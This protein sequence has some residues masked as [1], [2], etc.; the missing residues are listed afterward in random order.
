MYR[1]VERLSNMRLTFLERVYNRPRKH[2]VAH[3]VSKAEA[4]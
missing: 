3:F 2:L 1:G 4:L